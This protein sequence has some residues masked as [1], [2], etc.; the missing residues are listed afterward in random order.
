MVVVSGLSFQF[1]RGCYRMDL[2]FIVRGI[3]SG[4]GV[5]YVYGE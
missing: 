4:E 2:G 5:I 3:R 1:N